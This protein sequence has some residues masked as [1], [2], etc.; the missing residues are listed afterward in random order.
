MLIQQLR[1]LVTAEMVVRHDHGQV[2]PRV[3]YTMTPLGQ[4]LVETLRPLCEWGTHHRARIEALP[5]TPGH[6]TASAR[7]A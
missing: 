2:P 1:E 7:R 5:L 6:A 4:S 3:D